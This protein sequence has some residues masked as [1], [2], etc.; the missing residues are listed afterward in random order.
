MALLRSGPM[1]SGPMNLS[2]LPEEQR[3]CVS[4]EVQESAGSSFETAL[5]RLLRKRSAGESIDR[6]AV[7]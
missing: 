6:Q 1:R 4:K 3:S 7:T 2:P 5:S